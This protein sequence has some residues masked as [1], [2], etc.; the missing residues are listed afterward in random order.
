MV[1]KVSLAVDKGA[2]LCVVGESGSGKS[3][4]GLAIMRLLD[5][6]ADV[7]QASK[8]R[9]NGTNLLDLGEREMQRVRGAKI[10]MIFQEPMTALNPVYA[11]GYQIA[12]VLR[13]HQA[14]GRKE[15]KGRAMELLEQV[16]VPAPQARM[17]DYPHQMSGGMR[18][19]VMIAMALASG[20]DLLI[21]DE[22]TTALD[23]TIQA[24]I[25]D[26]LKSLQESLGMGLILITHDFGV[27]AQVAD[28]VAV[29]Y[30]GQIVERGSVGA[31]L[32]RPQHPYTEALLQ[33]MPAL[34]MN[35]KQPLK[36]IRGM[37]PNPTER[38][39]ACR[40][41]PRCDYAFDRCSAEEPP[42]FLVEEQRA[43]CWLCEHGPRTASG[44]EG[45]RPAWASQ[46]EKGESGDLVDE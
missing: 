39:S 5:P 32:E 18:Q 34:G 27:V 8:V 21:A 3:V 6:S 33:S 19:R 45:G 36:V 35:R 41:H 15:A 46:D 1:E 22:P 25:L 31:V 14:V 23:V 11:V 12:E 4:T 16:G 30:A 10:A 43:K 7:G 40:F 17:S 20:P 42:A 24:Q 9:F 26:L 2:T 13:Q 29:M 28:D 44:N 37:I 38:P